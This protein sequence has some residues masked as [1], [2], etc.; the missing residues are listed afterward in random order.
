MF[1]ANPINLNFSFSQYIFANKS[2]VLPT[3]HGK[4]SNHTANQNNLARLV[5]ISKFKVPPLKLKKGVHMSKTKMTRFCLSNIK[6]VKD[7]L[8]SPKHTKIAD[9]NNTLG[10][11]FLQD[12]SINMGIQ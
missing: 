3:N 1:S 7:F 8:F 6:K 2:F 9:L 4:M 5:L 12:V 10:V 11:P